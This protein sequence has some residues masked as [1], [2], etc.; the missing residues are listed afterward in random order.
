MA[1]QGPPFF[2]LSRQRSQCIKLVAVFAVLSGEKC[3]MIRISFQAMIVKI[4]IFWDLRA[5]FA[6]LQNG[7]NFDANCRIRNFN[8]SDGKLIARE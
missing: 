5:I 4:L 7:A 1:I 8:V 3:R 2:P 6:T